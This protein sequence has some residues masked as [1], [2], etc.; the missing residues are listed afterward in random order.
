[1][2]ANFPVPGAK[3]NYTTQEVHQ[4]VSDSLRPHGLEPCRI[5]SSWDSP[6]R[7]SGVGCHSLLQGSFP[8]Q[9]SNPRLLHLWQ[10]QAD[11]LPSQLP[12]SARSRKLKPFCFLENRE[13]GGGFIPRRFPTGPMWLPSPL[14]FN[15]AQS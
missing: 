14:F 11:P 13:H 3:T 8:T 2:M 6:G 10:W 1:M 12:E 5:L 15:T 9:G 4:H 7:N